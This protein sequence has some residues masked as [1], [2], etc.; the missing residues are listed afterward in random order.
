VKHLVFTEPGTVEWQEAPDPEPGPGEAVVRPLAVSRCDLDIPMTF[1]IFPGPYPVGHEIAA[2][3]VEVGEGVV[4]F[5]PGQRV[6]VP[7]Q[8]SCGACRFCGDDRF[9]A[10]EPNR[11]RAGAAFG[12]GESG[13]GH[14][15][16]LADY[17]LV[18]AAD[19]ML[20]AAPESIS[21]AALATI[22]DNVIDAYR[23]VVDGL[24]RWPGAEV[25]I[26][27]GDAPSISLYVIL[28]A[29]ALGS[30]RVRY[31]DSDTARLAAASDLGAE[32]IDVSEGFPRRFEQAPIV[33]SASLQTEGLHCAIHSTEPYGRI[34]P[35][36]IHFAPETPMP[37][38]SMYTRGITFH[39]SRADS[40]LYL[41]EV[42]DLVAGGGL[43]PLRVPTRL[44]PWGEAAERW[45]EPALK[46]VVTRD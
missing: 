8:V 29:K 41:Q 18:P 12:F 10:C 25:L 22:P 20:V 36:T 6:A 9:A 31:A 7:F 33:V 28:C 27:G 43:D 32:T 39:T 44:V 45:T 23:T 3:V 11:A 17:L 5:Q 4:S 19:H 16:G 2:E 46:M 13:G 15:G 24:R 37:L 21:D 40:R 1:G 14:G 26:V 35:V 30:G 42:L 38:L 34:V